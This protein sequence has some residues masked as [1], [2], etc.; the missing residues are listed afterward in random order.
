MTITI[1]FSAD[2]ERKLLARAAA[3]GKAVDALVREAVE[4]TLQQA[5][6]SFQEILAPIHD[7]FRK[8]GMT[9][10]ELD[11]LLK[12]TLA[13]VRRGASGQCLQVG[14]ERKLRLKVL[15]KLVVG[16]EQSAL[17]ALGQGDI[18]AV[19]DADPQ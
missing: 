4:E 1:H 10:G 7:D 12:D 8:S 15:D 11:T 3:T 18:E 17:L 9:E 6:P 16:G 5:L 2:M 19:V 14:D 13:Q